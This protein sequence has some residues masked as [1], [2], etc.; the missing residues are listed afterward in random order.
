MINVK[1]IIKIIINPTPMLTIGKINRPP[2]VKINQEHLQD[3][4][5]N[6]TTMIIERSIYIHSIYIYS[7]HILVNI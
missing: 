4:N 6:T 7:K 3:S 2:E 5:G 1:I